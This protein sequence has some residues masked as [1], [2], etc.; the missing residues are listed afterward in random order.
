MPLFSLSISQI[1]LAFVSASILHKLTFSR[2]F[3]KWLASHKF[4]CFLAPSNNELKKLLGRKPKARQRKK[5]HDKNEEAQNEV[6]K[7]QTSD[8]ENVKLHAAIMTV[9]DL[10]LL[11]YSED[12]EWIVDLALM[13]LFSYII[14]E[15]QFFVYPS[16]NDSNFSLLWALL[17]ITYCVKTL[18]K[19]TA[20]YF[21]NEQ[22]IGERS[23]CIVSGCFF[24][25]T[26]MVILI[27]SENYL[28]FGLES[29]YRSFNQSASAF[30]KHNK[31]TSESARPTTKPVSFILVKFSIA[32]ICSLVGL[33]FTFPGLKF[34]LLHKSLL[35][36]SNTSIYQNLVCNLNFIAPLF[37]VC[38]WIRPIARELVQRQ[39]YFLTDDTAFDIFRIYT[40]IF[41]SAFRFFLL[42]KYLSCFL[43]SGNKRVRKLRNRGGATTNR[44]L[45]V[46]ISG[47]IGYANVAALQYILPILMCLFTSLMLKSM[48]GLSWYPPST[49]V[50]EQWSNST[51]IDTS[52]NV[53]I[54]T[55]FT[56]ATRLFSLTRMID[57]TEFKKI[58]S[59]DLFR[60]IL[61]FSTWWLHFTW[62]CTSSAGVIYHT[63]LDTSD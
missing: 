2:F 42:P 27:V 57:L 1:L 32:V 6:F 28:E 24:L 25:L 48:G 35:D 51:I 10:E 55:S 26:A 19:L 41:I 52:L 21:R 20:T 62:L 9:R 34:G 4:V 16:T 50:S 7:I 39:S 8:L 5:F 23:I 14:T 45:Q 15:V 63:Y 33:V 49:V 11:H 3:L 47:I 43:S 17:V 59:P 40:I 61:G 58:F 12:L 38:L 37:V 18:W 56:N 46:S 53:S 30:V 13:S 22:T 31:L 36:K 54:E 44:E 29:A 60:G